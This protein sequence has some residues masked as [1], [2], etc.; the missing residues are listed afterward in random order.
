MRGDKNVTN[1]FDMVLTLGAVQKND[2]NTEGV[3]VFEFDDIAY[4][5]FAK[6]D[7]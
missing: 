3:A 4:N 1:K 2:E 6:G 7:E 5:P